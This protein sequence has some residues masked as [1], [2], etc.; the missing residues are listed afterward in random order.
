[1]IERLPRQTYLARISANRRFARPALQLKTRLQLERQPSQS[2]MARAYRQDNT[3][4]LD[5]AGGISV[6]RLTQRGWTGPDDINRHLTQPYRFI[7]LRTNAMANA[8]KGQ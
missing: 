7:K 8:H 1:L 5:F 3:A 6:N 4:I 2:D